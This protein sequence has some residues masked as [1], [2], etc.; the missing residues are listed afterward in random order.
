MRRR[1][2]AAWIVTAALGAWCA[3]VAVAAETGARVA[4]PIDRVMLIVADDLRADALGAYGGTTART[5]HLDA[6][7]S[8][9][10]VFTRMTCA[11]P[12]CNVSRSEMFSGRSHVGAGRGALKFEPGWTLWP[13]RMRA[14]GWHTVYAGKWHV[15]GTPARAGFGATAGLFSGGGAAGKSLTLASTPSGRTVTGYVGWTFKDADGK[16]LPELG[17]GLTP[18][19][20]GTIAERAIEAIGRKAGSPL[21]IHVNFT[22]PHDPL[23]WPPSRPGANRD[24][25]ELPLPK[26]FK[27]Q[28][29]FDTGNI[30][31]RDEKIVPAPRSADDVRRERAI[32]FRLV[33]HLDD[34]VGR[35]VAAL[36]SAGGLER[37]LIVFTSDHGLALGS[38]GL[39]G[40]QNQYEHTINVPFI[41]AGP[42]VPRG[43]TIAAQ[44]YL[45]DLYP[46]AC[47]LAGVSV[48]SSVQA[49]SLGPVLRGAQVEVHEAVFG[50]FTDTQRMVRTTDGWKLVWYPKLGTYQLFNVTDDPDELRDRVNESGQRGRVD[51]LKRRLAEWQRQVGDPLAEGKS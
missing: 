35:I 2:S 25:R 43:R 33:E 23:H 30:E 31:G 29:P 48:P 14:A 27:A 13:E 45:R 19:T 9:G 34:L 10:A 37:T 46:T 39:M 51:E 12:I 16:A 17:I 32:Y 36:E 49:R 44:G 7:A 6:L 42:G 1:T 40:K 18:Q 41:M 47:E 11:Y 5:P 22:A 4:P 20:D 21:F 8:R 38:H 3:G 15:D 50:Y 24:G 26:N 28:H